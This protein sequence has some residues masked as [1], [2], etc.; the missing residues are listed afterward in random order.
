MKTLIFG[1][2]IIVIASA[3]KL[4]LHS[5]ADF[6]E[7]WIPSHSQYPFELPPL[8]YPYDWV[9]EWVGPETMSAHHDNHHQ[10][11]VD[12]L[13]EGCEEDENL[14]GKTL[15]ELVTDPKTKDINVVKKH[16]GGH[17]YH[18]LFW[19]ILT[20]AH[21]DAYPLKGGKLEKAINEKWGSFHEFQMDFEDA[22]KGVFGSGWA[23]LASCS[24][25]LRIFAKSN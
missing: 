3:T 24:D 18:S 25:G 14:Q 7:E 4:S 2:S 9:D 11:Y 21:A 8:P 23:L 20:D 1:L 22:A 12:K 19:Y 5:K 13:N 10:T 6:K 16:G 17:Y 15:T